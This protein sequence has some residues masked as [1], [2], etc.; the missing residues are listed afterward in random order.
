MT[1]FGIRN[2][3]HRSHSLVHCNCTRCG[4]RDYHRS[5]TTTRYFS[6]CFVPLLPLGN[7]KILGE[8]QHCGESS[9]LSRRDFRSLL[10]TELSEAINSYQEDPTKPE[11]ASKI[12][13]AAIRTQHPDTLKKHAQQIASTFPKDAAMLCRLAE[14]FAFFCLDSYSSEYFLKSVKISTDPAIAK[15]AEEHAKRTG[16]NMPKP[17]N[18]LLQSV[19][20]LA[21][22]CLLLF[23]LGSL[24]SKVISNHP[25][26]A[27]LINGLDEAYEVY[28]NDKLVQLAPFERLKGK[29]LRY[30]ENTIRPVMASVPIPAETFYFPKG[31]FGNLFNESLY[32]VNPDRSALLLWETLPYSNELAP[33]L[34]PRFKLLSGKSHYVQTDIDYIFL[35]PPEQIML[36]STKTEFRTCIS[37]WDDFNLEGL[38]DI[39]VEYDLSLELEKYLAQILRYEKDDSEIISAGRDRLP[40]AVFQSL[41]KPHIEARPIRVEWHRAY[42]D[43][44]EPSEKHDLERRYRDLHESDPNNPR[45]AYLYARVCEF[46]KQA[47]AVLL[48]AVESSQPSGY[49]CF[50]L[51]YFRMLEGD[52]RS[53]IE[54]SEKASRW[55][56]NNQRFHYTK[57]IALY[58]LKD[59]EKLKHWSEE[60][61]NLGLDFEVLY[62]FAYAS[63]KIGEKTEAVHRINMEL[64]KW[65]NEFSVLDEEIAD[66]RSYLHEAIALAASSREEYLKNLKYGSTPVDRFE[67][68]ILEGRLYDGIYLASQTE[69]VFDSSD[70]LLLAILAKQA[71]NEELSQ[72]QLEM[73]CGLLVEYGTEESLAWSKWLSGED[74]PEMTKLV[75]TCT[76]FEQQWLLFVALAHLQDGEQ[77][78]E[79]LAHAKKINV[80][81]TFYGL[82]L[83]EAKAF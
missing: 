79:Y 75:Q 78:T 66:T 1:I 71:G 14:A 21:L 7:K 73:A 42:Q 69:N 80:Q 33:E 35:D 64:N 45:L 26:N 8:C 30:G 4:R 70:F 52:H 68:H 39:L 27:Y 13:A 48:A 54:Y 10:N 23:L 28:V 19:S 56:P 29:F 81:T 25:E 18:R 24:I 5:Y 46:P 22:P 77:A 59:F 49:A 62:D 37:H 82:A 9:G 55:L 43:L 11:N 36:L 60:R 3:N 74:M 63:T 38:I 72:K 67:E 76:Y 6:L 20:V 83:N 17:P 12:I 58:G 51:S 44:H 61:L 34:E 32:L 2:F 16:E 15:L 50:G 53:S 31:D 41:A 40:E 47:L 65:R 57:K